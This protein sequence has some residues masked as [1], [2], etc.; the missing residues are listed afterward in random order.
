MGKDLD[1]NGG[2]IHYLLSPIKSFYENT[3]KEL[4]K[5]YYKLLKKGVA[6]PPS[7]TA[8]VK[9]RTKEVL[10][11]LFS[12]ALVVKNTDV[13]CLWYGD[14]FFWNYNYSPSFGDHGD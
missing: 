12:G 10:R 7:L 8:D 6:N 5:T 4:Y 1:K 13:N 2:K 3:S 9:E 14:V 11:P